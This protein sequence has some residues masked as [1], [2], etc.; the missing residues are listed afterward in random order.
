VVAGHGADHAFPAWGAAPAAG[1]H[2]LGAGFIKDHDG[3]GVDLG[4]LRPP[5]SAGDLIPFG[6]DQGLFLSGSPSRSSARL[7]V[8]RLTGTWPSPAHWAQWSTSV[9]SGRAAT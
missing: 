9:A 6:G 3:L 1:H 2:G 8:D 7:I 5:G 4:Y